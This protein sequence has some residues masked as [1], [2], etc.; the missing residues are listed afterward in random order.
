MMTELANK[1]RR[2]PPKNTDCM[3]IQVRNIRYQGR[4]IL[5]ARTGG[6][7]P[8]KPGSPRVN[9]PTVMGSIVSVVWAR[10][11]GGTR[12]PRVLLASRSHFSALGVSNVKLRTMA[13]VIN[14]LSVRYR[15]LARLSRT[16]PPSRPPAAPPR[17]VVDAISLGARASD[18]SPT[19]RQASRPTHARPARDAPST[20]L[21]TYSSPSF[22]S[23]RAAGGRPA[24]PRRGRLGRLQVLRWLQEGKG[25][26]LSSLRRLRQGVRRRGPRRHLPRRRRRHLLRRRREDQR[27]PG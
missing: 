11:L 18:A 15:P 16:S 8:A 13:A 21:P 22:P 10:H 24:P 6:T 1:I 25:D 3:L 20:D 17:R 4:S 26:A 7:P 5:G 2:I 12:H 14:F 19:R 27:P 9:F 23:A